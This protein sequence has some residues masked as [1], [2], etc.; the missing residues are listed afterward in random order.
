M[1]EI[2]ARNALLYALKH[3]KSVTI[4]LKGGV[5]KGIKDGVYEGVRTGPLPDGSGFE[6][7]E[8]GGRQ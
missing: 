5:E 8:L 4:M 1:D 2:S 6:A 7:V 3:G